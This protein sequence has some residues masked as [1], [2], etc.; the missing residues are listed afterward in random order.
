MSKEFELVDGKKSAELLDVEQAKPKNAISEFLNSAVYTATSAPL[1]GL[2]QIA[3]HKLETNIDKTVKGAFEAMGVRAPEPAQFN[4]SNWYAQ[5]LG[6]AVGMTIPFLALRSGVKGTASLAFGE[7]AVKSALDTGLTHSLSRF[8]VQEAAL[9]GTAGFLYGSILNPSDEKLVGTADFGKDRLKHGVSDLAVFGSLSLTA[10]F[11]GKGLATGST[12]LEGRLA[13]P[14]LKDGLAATLRGPMLPGALSGVPAGLVAAEATA[15][16]DGRL[17]PTG[18]ELKESVTGMVVVGGTL[19]TAHWLGA[20]REGTNVTNAR[21]LTDR[22]GLTKAADA[23]IADF[24]VVEGK[25]QLSRFHNEVKGGA[26]NAEA[27]IVVRQRLETLSSA[28]QGPAGKVWGDARVLQLEHRGNGIMPARTAGSFGLIGTCSILEGPASARDVFT[29]RSS[30]ADRT[31]MLTPR[32]NFEQFSLSVGK[33]SANRASSFPVS[34]RLSPVALGEESNEAA[35]PTVDATAAKPEDAGPAIRAQVRPYKRFYGP[36]ETPREDG[37]N[38]FGR[39]LDMSDSALLGFNKTGTVSDINKATSVASFGR[40]ATGWPY[41]SV[42]YGRELWSMNGRGIRPGRNY[43]DVKGGD[44]LVFD[45]SLV[46]DFQKKGYAGEEGKPPSYEMQLQYRVDAELAKKLAPTESTNPAEARTADRDAGRDRRDDRSG[47]FGDRDGGRFGDRDGGRFGD[48]DGRFR[49]G[50]ET[51]PENLRPPRPRGDFEIG[52]GKFR[53][54]GKMLVRPGDST[55]IP[56]FKDG[57]R[58]SIVANDTMAKFGLDAKGDAYFQVNHGQ[59]M[60]SLNGAPI[61][62]KKQYPISTND[63]LTFNG[64]EF[65]L[66][67][68]RT[69]HGNEALDLGIKPREVTPQTRK[70]VETTEAPEGGTSSGAPALKPD[71]SLIPEG[72]F[73]ER[74]YIAS[75]ADVQRLMSTYETV[76][77]EMAAR[78]AAEAAEQEI[79]IENRPAETVEGAPAENRTTPVESSAEAKPTVEQTGSENRPVEA[80]GKP[81]APQAQT[82]VENTAK[83]AETEANGGSATPTSVDSILNAA[84]VDGVLKPLVLTDEA[85]AFPKEALKAPEAK[86]TNPA[87]LLETDL[88]SINGKDLAR[89][90]ELKIGRF[91]GIDIQLAKDPSI[92]NMHGYVGLTADGQLYIRNTSTNGMQVNGEAIESGQ[93]VFIKPNDVVTVGR[94]NRAIEIKV[95]RPE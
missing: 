17:L 50:P 26:S 11:I 39:K 87:E 70:A 14:V 60:W 57:K 95:D 36:N 32:A 49:D 73:G 54:F 86:N 58:G 77:K 18:Q 48:R 78:K 66:A 61:E 30:A 45:N 33:D 56:L 76:Q 63:K 7:T 62:A 31:V 1:R 47:R 37:F 80:E 15:L 72:L 4:T 28:I 27:Q 21:H 5:Q 22:A 10:P 79:P 3:D 59:E 55:M 71:L 91:Q 44:K 16:R 41:F 19:S 13:S 51:P 8:A 53:V 88:V 29:G 92:A 6:G 20:Q 40:D 65:E 75:P 9:S 67:T 43:L 82:G 74:S 42:D 2:A 52:E 38:I 34:E 35:K 23:S 84:S 69:P 64:N 90:K 89:G 85:R 24:K 94:N 81:E 83:P 46:F 12:F 93:N 25:D 68:K